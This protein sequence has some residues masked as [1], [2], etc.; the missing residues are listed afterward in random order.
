MGPPPE[1]SRMSDGR[2]RQVVFQ[3]HPTP[4]SAMIG[5]GR[6]TGLSSGTIISDRQDR[7]NSA[8]DVPEHIHLELPEHPAPVAAHVA[9]LLR[10][11]HFTQ[12]PCLETRNIVRRMAV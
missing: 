11:G 5:P 2:I 8:A 10:G 7:K 6:F 3:G 12:L 1:H 4:D 9:W